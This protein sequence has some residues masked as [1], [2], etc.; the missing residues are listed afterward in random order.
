MILP[1]ARLED[2]GSYTCIVS[3]SSNTQEKTAFL[4]LKARPNFPYPLQN[5]HLDEGSD[6]EWRCNAVGVPLPTYTWFKNGVKLVD[7]ATTGITQVRGNILTIRGVNTDHEGM[8]LCEAQN[9]N[10]FARSSAQLRS[11]TLAP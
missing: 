9:S 3:S 2:S 4:S 6:F 5:Q 7:D 11:L 10:G 1:K 8:Y